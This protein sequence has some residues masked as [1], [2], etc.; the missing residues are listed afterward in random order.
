MDS[1]C[2]CNNCDGIFIDTNPQIGAIKIDLG[3]L[4]FKL[5]ELK[6]HNCPKCE[7]DDY[8]T[9]LDNLETAKA[10]WSILGDVPVNEDDELDDNFLLFEKGSDKFEVWHWF[11][12][13][14]DISVAKDLMNI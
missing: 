8:L 14:F 13:K 4:Y 9:D 6:D 7:T 10:L 5:D 2:R 1:I 12:D 3:S 11:E